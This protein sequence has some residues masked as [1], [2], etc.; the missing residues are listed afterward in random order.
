MTDDD[1]TIAIIN[2]VEVIAKIIATAIV[3]ESVSNWWSRDC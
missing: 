2:S 3:K 1:V